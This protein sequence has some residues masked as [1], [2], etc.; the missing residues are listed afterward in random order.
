MSERPWI[1]AADPAS[2]NGRKAGTGPDAGAGSRGDQPELALRL[3][4]WDLVPPTELLR[5]RRGDAR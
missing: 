2:T 1:P 5:R 3:P 4:A